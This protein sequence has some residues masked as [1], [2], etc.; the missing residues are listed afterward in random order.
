MKVHNCSVF[1][2]NHKKFNNSEEY[3]R[4]K[5]LVFIYK[6]PLN[7]NK[8]RAEKH[9]NLP[10]LLLGFLSIQSKSVAPE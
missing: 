4:R 8:Q 1:V 2:V 3:M 7:I 10:W 9:S 6:N 5:V